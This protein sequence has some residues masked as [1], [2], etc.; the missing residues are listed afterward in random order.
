M[1]STEPKRILKANAIRGLGSKIAFNYEDLRRQCDEYVEKVCRQTRRMIQDAQAESE[2]IRKRTF[3]EGEQA[4]RRQGLREADRDIEKRATQLAEQMTSLS[5]QLGELSNTWRDQEHSKFREE[6]E[7]HMK[8]ILRFIE[9]NNE[10]IP[11][12]LRKA[13]RI[14]EYMQQR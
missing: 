2:S 3:E 9:V 6:F 11:Y 4:G 5:S 13:E 10:H 8:M 7:Q 1:A 14:E 12:L